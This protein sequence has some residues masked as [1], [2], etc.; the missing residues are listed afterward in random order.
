MGAPRVSEVAFL[1][2]PTR[3]L[4]LVDS[5]FNHTTAGKPLLTKAFL[6]LDG[7]AKG[8]SIT[9]VFKLMIKDKPAFRASLRELLAWDFERVLVGHGAIT[10]GADIQALRSLMEAY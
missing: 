8:V 10:Q 6:H 4:I 2:E 1:H 5:V 3:T 9:R 7:A